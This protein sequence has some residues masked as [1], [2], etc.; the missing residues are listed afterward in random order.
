[1]VLFYFYKGSK[2]TSLSRLSCSQVPGFFLAPVQ[3]SMCFQHWS[4]D[5]TVVSCFSL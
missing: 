2:S 5:E 3:S 1:M 4:M